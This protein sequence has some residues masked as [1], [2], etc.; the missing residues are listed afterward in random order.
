[1]QRVAAEDANG[2]AWSSQF[3]VLAEMTEIARLLERL[4]AGKRHAFDSLARE[5]RL[6]DFFHALIAST[7]E[8]MTR[9]VKAAA[10]VQIASLEPYDRSLARAIDR[11]TGQH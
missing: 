2:E 3:D 9:W 4:S 6:G 7:I 1:L 8:E 10:T 5:N 11:A